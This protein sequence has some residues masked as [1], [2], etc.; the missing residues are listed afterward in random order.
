MKNILFLMLGLIV[1]TAS[2]AQMTIDK[3]PA[4][5]VLL[6]SDNKVKLM[7]AREEAT[8]TITL[9]DSDG[10]ILY[11]DKQNLQNGL[12]QY[13]NVSQLAYGVYQL[14]ISVGKESIVKTFE[15]KELP[16]QQVVTLAS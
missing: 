15:V 11:V 13:F 10:H 16:S 9:R 5:T 7:V 6:T 3:T 8:A 1:S 2:F 12:R 14:S 4:A